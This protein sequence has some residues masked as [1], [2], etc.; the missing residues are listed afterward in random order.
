MLST[1]INDQSCVAIIEPTGPLSEHDFRCAA[2]IIDPWLY[3]HGKL[4]GL[5][6]RASIFP[7]WGSLAATISHLSFVKDH[8]K[9]D[10]RVALVTDSPFGELGEKL[11]SHFAVAEIKHFPY[12]GIEDAKVWDANT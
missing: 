5:I 7:G 4:N 11:A 2:E 9:K 6:F 10:S 3:Q 1:T 8:H 12:S